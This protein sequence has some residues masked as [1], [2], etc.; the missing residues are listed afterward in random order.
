MTVINYL[1]VEET[2]AEVPWVADS[3]D[4][5]E[6]RERNAV[7]RL[8]GIV[9]ASYISLNDSLLWVQAEVSFI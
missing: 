8:E 2:L 7:F 1:K 4:T 3:A 9:L 5:P 6:V